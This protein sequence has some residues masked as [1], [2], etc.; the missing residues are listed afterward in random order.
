MVS[1]TDLKALLT[2]CNL[3]SDTFF[4]KSDMV[5][6]TNLPYFYVESLFA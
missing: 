1:V 3:R 6:Q 5:G 4:D 2:R